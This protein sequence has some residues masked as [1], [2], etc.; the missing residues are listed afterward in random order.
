VKNEDDGVG[1][2]A[3]GDVGEGVEHGP[4]ARDLEGLHGDGVGLIGLGV[5]GD[6]GRELL[7][8]KGQ[9]EAGA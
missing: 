9:R 1:A 7:C 6:G 3:F 2:R 4:V 8:V 5:G